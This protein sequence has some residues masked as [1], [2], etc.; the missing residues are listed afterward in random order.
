M[1]D[2]ESDAGPELPLEAPEAD[3][4]EQSA[5]AWDD[6]SQRVQAPEP[7]PVREADP[8]DVAEQS[9]PVPSDD[10]DEPG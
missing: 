8:A 6:D 5:Q 10:A 3:V 4:A 1:T 7:D 9:I 2:T